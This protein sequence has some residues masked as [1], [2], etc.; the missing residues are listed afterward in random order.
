MPLVETR[1]SDTPHPFSF[2][3]PA[4][5]INDENDPGSTMSNSRGLPSSSRSSQRRPLDRV[6]LGQLDDPV[7]EN[8][9]RYLN[10][11]LPPSQRPSTSTNDIA[12]QGSPAEVEAMLMATSSDEDEPQFDSRNARRR[13]FRTQ[14]PAMVMRTRI[15][16]E[17]LALSLSEPYSR[18]EIHP[19]SPLVPGGRPATPVGPP[20]RRQPP[21]E[22]RRAGTPVL[23]V[24]M[25]DSSPV[26]VNPLAVSPFLV[27]PFHIAR[28]PRAPFPIRPRRREWY[29]QE[30]PDDLPP[31]EDIPPWPVS[32]ASPHHALHRYM[33]IGGIQAAWDALWEPDTITGPSLDA[34]RNASGSRAQPKEYVRP[35]GKSIKEWIEEREKALAGESRGGVRLPRSVTVEEVPEEEA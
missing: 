20:V 26:R 6:P 23:D 16:G 15:T 8:D 13:Q 31:L 3:Y 2:E 34:V 29:P 9:D 18:E 22:L 11:M 14:S 17:Q 27:P 7:E 4:T 21:L 33:T 1:A 32:P 24:E 5:P 25:Q 19:G 30:D 35:A 12:S 28:D 10:E